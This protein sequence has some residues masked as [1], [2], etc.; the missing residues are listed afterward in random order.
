MLTTWKDLINFTGKELAKCDQ[1]SVG[2]NQLL[3]LLPAR[4]AKPPNKPP[5]KAVSSISIVVFGK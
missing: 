2:I 3:R 1:D 5:I 4:A